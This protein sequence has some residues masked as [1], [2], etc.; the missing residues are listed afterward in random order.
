[1]DQAPQESERLDENTA[2]FT[3][4]SSAHEQL[5]EAAAQARDHYDDNEHQPV[6]QRRFRVAARA[7]VVRHTKHGGSASEPTRTAEK[8]PRVPARPRSSRRRRIETSSQ[9]QVTETSGGTR[10]P[11]RRRFYPRRGAWWRHTALLSFLF[12]IF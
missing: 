6:K 2:E 7:S 1:M 3:P 12:P 9:E 8:E 11:G 5:Q 10:S 4:I